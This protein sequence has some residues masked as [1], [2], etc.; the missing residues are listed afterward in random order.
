MKIADAV[1]ILNEP[2]GSHIDN[3][4]IPSVGR[5]VM[6]KPLT[7]ADVK[8]LTRMN[9]LTTFDLNI[10]GLKLGLF[11]KLCAEDLSD[12]A[13]KDENDEIIHPPVSAKT[14][15]Q[16]DYLAF[17]I[18]IRK[19]LNNEVTYTFT[20]TKQHCHQKFDHVLN[21]EKNFNDIITEFKRQ[22]ILFEVIDERTSN[23]WK[24]ELSNF[25]MSEYL[26]FR[27]FIERLRVADENSPDVEFNTKFVKPI[28]YIKNIWINNELVEDW[29]AL[30]LPEK[31]SFFNQIP[32]DITINTLN[33]NAHTVYTKI[34][35]AFPE[36]KLSD[37]IINL[38]VRCPKCGQTYGGVFDFDSFF[39]F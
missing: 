15:T 28:L 23:I 21:L 36:E 16:I 1:K 5:E 13:E 17:L 35:E 3:I 24:F 11:D 30:T 12:T 37:K 20:C 34:R 2:T 22:R 33:N 38:T 18:G 8:T 19:M 27:Y 10:E 39:M 32:P 25:T 14:I 7:T 6:F 31:L 9:F 26:Y 29:P 4:Y